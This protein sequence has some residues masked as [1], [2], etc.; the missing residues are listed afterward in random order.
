M[1]VPATA[2]QPPAPKVQQPPSFKDVHVDKKPGQSTGQALVTINGKVRRI[3]TNALQAWPIVNAQDALVL[4]L[5]TKASPDQYRLRF[6]EGATRK[7]RELGAVPFSSAKLIEQQ[8]DGHWMFAFAGK[9]S[10][11][12]VLIVADTE[13]I[14]GEIRGAADPTFESSALAYK[15]A[16]S[17]ESRRM[18]LD[19]ILGADMRGIHRYR[20]SQFLQFNQDGTAVL[21]ERTGEF[22]AGTWRTDGTDMTFIPK[23][24]VS[25]KFPRHELTRIEG[26]PA[27]TRL[28]VRLLHPLDSRTVNEGDPVRAVVITP[29]SVDG[30]ILI[31]Q[32]SEMSGT[33]VK[34][35]GV[36]W[37][38]LHES[39]A[40][41]LDLNE[42]KL[43]DGRSLKIHTR[44]YQVENSRETVDANG[45]IRGVR[46]TGTL[47]HSAESK[48]SS[49]A[50]V[51]PVAYLFTSVSATA[52]LGFAEPEILYPAG[53]EMDI[54]FTSPLIT[55]QVYPSN[56]PPL[57]RKPGEGDLGVFVHTVPFRTM[58]K[59][60]NKP[61]DLTNLLFIGS[62]DGLRRAFEAAG[63]VP[64]DNLNA[65][66]T[67][68]TLK[69]L[70]GNETYR[71]APMSTLLL[72]ERPPIL[73]LS[74]TT[75]TFSSRHH[76]RVFDPALRYGGA[77]VLTS[78]ST[79]DIGIAFSRKQKTFIHVID[80]YIDNERSKVVNDLTY[81]GCV[82][83]MS[84]VPRPWV[85]HDA[86]NS[87]GD[88]LR[89]DGAIA[90]LRINDCAH[91]KTSPDDEP[92][93]PPRVQ[94]IARDTMLVLRN[95]LW[96]GNLVY[97]GI[98]GSIKLRSYL[99]TKDELKADPGDWRKND[100]S[101]TE[102]EGA[103]NGKAVD[104]DQQS[105]VQSGERGGPPAVEPPP[106]PSHRWDPPRYEIG[107]Q[108]GFL[109]YPTTRTDA[110][111]ILAT[112]KDPNGDFFA[113][114]LSDQVDGGWTAGLTLTSNTWRWFSNEF[115][116]QYQ[117]GKYSIGAEVL[118]NLDV[119]PDIQPGRVGLVTRQF[120]YNLLAHLRPP[121]SR[122]RPYIAVGPVLQLISLADSPIKKPAGPFK[123]GAG[124]IGILV[125]AFDFGRTPPLEGGGIFQLGFQY[126]AGIKFRVHPR[127]TIRADFRETLSKN[128]EFIRD[129][130][131][132]DFFFDED[133]NVEFQHIRP[134][135]KFRQQRFTLGVAFTF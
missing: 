91:P 52:V 123:L 87:T 23:T 29:A 2:Q 34:A 80:E 109:R 56:V 62:P 115:S 5:D 10:T 21:E 11:S 35:H 33:I 46:S 51:D 128:P 39:A 127:I 4:W 7:R 6:V 74:K 20:D 70:S 15:D 27:G 117:R 93:Q 101:G 107:L 3:A 66:S 99:K 97:Q 81:T 69:T 110:L 132:D 126:G 106:E 98:T 71:E 72:D 92:S 102:Y 17:G 78:S 58:T 84:L 75:N 31:P 36:G 32:G 90:V 38:V 113:V 100:L 124:N 28:D 8:H 125:A 119:D 68:Q 59:G 114:I 129:S 82:D 64:T 1:C 88:R 105:S 96:R 24:G 19:A 85:P 49:I 79:Q 54:E 61:S 86:Y 42:A 67:F 133:Y 41:T 22:Q 53:T 13:A 18:P 131:T 130:Y 134:E 16:A 76:L 104:V 122:W 37:G 50:A 47:G 83:A 44:L 48:I 43:P 40:L 57:T 95:D 9:D 103:D 121:E 111:G 12:P 30:H 73:T 25:I 45:T 118:T 60:S 14:H 63:W 120:D 135:A 116:Y 26:V 94:R 89:T 108:G 77:T 112:P 55:S 65:S